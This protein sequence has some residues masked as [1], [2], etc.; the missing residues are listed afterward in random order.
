MHLGAGIYIPESDLCHL[1]SQRLLVM[2]LP[3]LPSHMDTSSSDSAECTSNCEGQPTPPRIRKP[4]PR[5][6]HT[7]SR[8]G[9]FNCKRRRIKC[10]EQRPGCNHC[11]KAGL[12]CEY[13]VN[14]IQAG[15]PVPTS[16]GPQQIV[17][18][19]STPGTFVR[20]L[21]DIVCHNTDFACRRWLICA[22]SIIS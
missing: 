20:P 22:S 3:S 18:L 6:G 9:C 5:K 7:K 10:N 1:S 2:P 13:P 17:S 15:Q 19:R 21:V 16:P 8:R 12:H 14:I 11:I 4:I